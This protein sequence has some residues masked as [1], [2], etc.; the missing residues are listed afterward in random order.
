MNRISRSFY[1]L[2]PVFLGPSLVFIFPPHFFFALCIIIITTAQKY[3]GLQSEFPHH[4]RPS[5]LALLRRKDSGA[6]KYLEEA[7][8]VSTVALLCLRSCPDSG[9]A[10]NHRSL[11]I[12]LEKAFLRKLSHLLTLLAARVSIPSRAITSS[13]SSSSPIHILTANL[14]IFSRILL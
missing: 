13:T 10:T 7:A 6:L 4:I 8:R 14:F 1:S 9:R 3:S 11:N 2:S 5:W 12:G